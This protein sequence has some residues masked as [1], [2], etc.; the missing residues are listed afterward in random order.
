MALLL[1][2][3]VGSS[4][5]K[6]TLLE[7]QTGKVLA[8]ATSPEKELQI[9][10][11]KLGWAE[12]HPHVWWE[13]VK[14]A[15]RKVASKIRNSKFE[16]RNVEAIGISY[17]MHGLVVLDKNKEVLR[18]SIIWCDSRA[19]EIGQKAA[20]DIGEEKCL[21]SLLNLPGNFTASKLKWVME[22]EPNIFSKIYKIMLPGDYIAMKM[23]GQI[24]TTP[25]GLSEG[26]MWDFQKQGL[27][28]LVLDYYGITEDL[29]AEVVPTF[30]V[31]GEL[32]KKAADELG[33]KAGTKISY[34]AGDQPNN[35]LSLNVLNP[36]EIAAT[37]G[38]SGVVYGITETSDY[39]SKSRVNTFVHVNHTPKAPRY[40]VLLCLNGTGILNSWLKH[41]ASGGIDYDEMNKL[42][43]SVDVGS[44]GLTILPYGNGAE[45]TLEN[46]NLGASI[47]GLNFNIH[48]R[49]HLLRA[50][51]EGIVFALNYGL[52]IM[53]KTGVEVKT[54]RA[55]NA[56]M[57]LSP[58][59]GQ[60]FATVTGATV[61]LYN[62]DGSQG[63]AR[64]AGIG[65]GIYKGPEEAFAGLKPVMMIE[66]NKKL[67]KKYQQ[68]YENWENVLN[69]QLS[70][71]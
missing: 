10:A 52:G 71:Q 5:I 44:D 61:E 63:A 31:Q 21:K 54:V 69:H 9:I 11:K 46:R 43:S 58:L 65:A 37:A 41:N 39:D 62:T 64:G 1:G 30:S 60:A 17:Q 57:F 51:Q 8:T 36:G 20:A 12:Q 56:N 48:T 25:S 59:F 15:T 32:T 47:H 7:A 22:N 45:R 16:I 2:Y 35:A 18:P 4:S 67:A 38:T 23:T 29:V 49:A 19:V 40:G 3:D 27:A 33:L 14:E 53:R 6:A 24:K 28:K 70:V 66:P 42:A 34:R 50:A 26:I 55:G 68:A 13:H